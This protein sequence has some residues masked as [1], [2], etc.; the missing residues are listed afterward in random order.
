MIKDTWLQQSKR[1]E[2]N[3]IKENIVQ[4]I[5]L[6]LSHVDKESQSEIINKIQDDKIKQYIFNIHL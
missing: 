6:L 5:I 3:T 2:E 4:M 1:K